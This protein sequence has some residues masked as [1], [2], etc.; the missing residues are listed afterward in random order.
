MLMV[1]ICILDWITVCIVDICISYETFNFLIKPFNKQ[2]ISHVSLALLYFIFFFL[3]SSCI[4]SSI[5]SV[6]CV[7]EK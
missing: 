3:F 4:L 5:A 7:C 2:E 1:C 6:P